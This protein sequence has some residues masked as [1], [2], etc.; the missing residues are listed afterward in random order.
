MITTKTKQKPGGHLVHSENC[1]KLGNRLALPF[2]TFHLHLFLDFLP[3]FSAPFD[4]TLTSPHLSV[5][6]YY[7][8]RIA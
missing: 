4:L 3:Y 1:S 6:M 2:F 8:I 5:L 7:H